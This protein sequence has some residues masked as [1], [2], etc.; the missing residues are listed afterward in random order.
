MKFKNVEELKKFSEDL[1]NNNLFEGFDEKCDFVN[2][3]CNKCKYTK[4][5]NAVIKLDDDLSLIADI[6]KELQL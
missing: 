1:I 5:C 3:N 4:Y 6:V 2:G